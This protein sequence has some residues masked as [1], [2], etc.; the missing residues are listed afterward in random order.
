[1]KDKLLQSLEKSQLRSIG[2]GLG[3]TGLD[4]MRKDQLIMKLS[5]QSYNDI[6]RE[7]EK[8]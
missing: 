3:L 8:L 2:S 1:M 5:S 7:Y 4:K 6:V